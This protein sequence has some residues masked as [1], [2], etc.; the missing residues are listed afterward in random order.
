MFSGLVTR[1]TLKR[2]SFPKSNFNARYTR[3]ENKKRYQPFRLT[4]PETIW[5]VY[6]IRLTDS[7]VL[8]Y[9]ATFGVNPIIDI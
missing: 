5:S 6:F 7:D 3:A 4:D 2:K 1:R 8:I 9:R